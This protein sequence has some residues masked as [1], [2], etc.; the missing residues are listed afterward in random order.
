VKNFEIARQFD[1]MADLLEIKGENPFRI[2]AYRRASQNVESLTEDVEALGAAGRLDEIPG[3][4][5]D[6]AG[7]ITE[8]LET[9]RIKDVEAAKKEI[10]AGVVELMNVPGVGPKTAK[11]LYEKA[12][13]HGVSMLERLAKA[14]RLKGL[15]GIQA[16]TEANILKGIAVVR[17][18]QSRMLLGRALPLAQELAHAL[19]RVKEVEQLSLAGS[20]RRRKETVGDIDILVTSV[21][22]EK[23]ME[24]FTRL[25][26]VA[27][28]LERGGTKA[29]VRHREGIQVDLRVVE[30]AAFGAA[31]VYFTGSKQHN[32]RIREM[33]Q[34]KGLKISEYGVF[35]ESTGRRVAGKTEEEVY[36]AIG[37][38][39]IPPELREDAGEVEAALKRRLPDLVEVG[40]I[41]GDLHDHTNASDG[42]HSIEAL[43]EAA[44]KRGYQYILVSDHS[45]SSR[46]ARGLSA[47]KLMAHVKKIRAVQ[48]KHRDIRV[49]AGSEC[50]ILADGSLDYPDEVLAELDL[51][52]AAVHARFKQPRPEMT[53]RICRALGNPYVRILAHP[54]GR[55]IGER[56][57]YDVDLDA[58]FR[59][60]KEHDKAVE[61]NSYPQRLD[62][63]DV[64]A[65][66]AAEM[67]V[68]VAI[69]TDAHVLDHLDNVELGV[70]TARRA[71]IGPD[72]VINAWPLGRLLAWSQR[73]RPARPAR[74]RTGG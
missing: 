65:R 5:E 74:R 37:L 21:R 63:N 39:W 51:V 34:K 23:V 9:G 46:V 28:V 24:A 47:D 71:W 62:L 20:I 43:V 1:L 4:G 36:A 35:K 16:K 66:R 19:E 49:L 72:R 10:P 56:D 58:V 42:H 50:D 6:L 61:I 33:A 7:K 17:Q 54:T 59:A 15:P 29:S 11:L 44:R 27:D 60:A 52:V 48:K 3:I 55:L 30:P 32:I 8:Y 73:A 12:G 67:G 14:G 26:Q 68:L 64:H 25:P 18:G 53:R 13:V 40:D 69:N 70:A 57:P 22:P 31:L 45:Q 38:P 41:K 2:R